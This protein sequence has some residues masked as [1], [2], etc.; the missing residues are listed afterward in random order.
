MRV[1]DIKI[2]FS[3]IDNL[4]LYCLGSGKQKAMQM[5]INS[6]HQSVRVNDTK[7]DCEHCSGT[8]RIDRS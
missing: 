5:A 8:G 2:E 7:V 1:A 4:C 3:N 6:Q